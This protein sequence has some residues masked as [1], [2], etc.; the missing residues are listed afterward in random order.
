M[1]PDLIAVIGELGILIQDHKIPDSV[2]DEVG[3]SRELLERLIDVTLQL[4]DRLQ[5][6]AA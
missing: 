1:Q 5:A 6:A 4:R 2:L 3:A